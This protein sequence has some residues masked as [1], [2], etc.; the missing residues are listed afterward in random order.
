M[1]VKMPQTLVQRKLEGVPFISRHCCLE[2]VP[3]R[4]DK[5]PITPDV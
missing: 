2:G 5:T 1:G 3:F 4:H